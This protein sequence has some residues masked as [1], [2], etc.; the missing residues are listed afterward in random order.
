[1]P[2]DC[3]NYEWGG[4][5]T[6]VK[7]TKA[8]YEVEHVLE[9]QVVTKFFDW[10]YEIKKR[11]ET[12]PGPDTTSERV[13]FCAYFINSWDRDPYTSEIDKEN[14]NLVISNEAQ[15]I[16]IDGETKTPRQFLADEFPGTT[17][18]EEFVMLEANINA[19]A[20][21]EVI[22]FLGRWAGILHSLTRISIAGVLR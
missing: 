8:L 21:A 22:R 19:P 20:K 14:N 16:T 15:P 18:R 9:W 6:D 1:M 3:T 12:F 10:I 11:T 2:K 5:L 4:P 17:F 7:S 13:N